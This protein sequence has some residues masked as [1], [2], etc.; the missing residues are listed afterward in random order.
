MIICFDQWQSLRIKCCAPNNSEFL[1]FIISSLHFVEMCIFMSMLQKEC[2]LSR[3]KLQDT[4]F[5]RKILQDVRFARQK[6]HKT[7]M[8]QSTNFKKRQ[9]RKF[10][11]LRSQHNKLLIKRDLFVLLRLVGSYYGCR[12][13]WR[14]IL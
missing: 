10:G 7:N 3:H 9:K 4:N 13:V 1:H 14:I 8:S 12:E 11:K 6:C 2:L 5:E